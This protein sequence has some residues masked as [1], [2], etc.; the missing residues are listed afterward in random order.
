MNTI[1]T[2]LNAIEFMKCKIILLD[3]DP[4]MPYGEKQQK[5]EEMRAC[6]I[7]AQSSCLI[8]CQE[9]LDLLSKKAA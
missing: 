7:R 4:F 1:E 9:N 8:L 3:D 2:L 5:L 6:L